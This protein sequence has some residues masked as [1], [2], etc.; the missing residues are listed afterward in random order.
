MPSPPASGCATAAP[1]VESEAVPVEFRV[2]WRQ[3]R[4]AGLAL[5][6]LTNEFHAWLSARGIED[7]VVLRLRS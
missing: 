6:D 5:S 4:G 7:D 3:L 1:E 2:Q